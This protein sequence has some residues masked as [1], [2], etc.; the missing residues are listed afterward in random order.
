M[1]D[2]E[3]G[4]EERGL[5]RVHVVENAQEGNDPRTN[6][7]KVLGVVSLRRGSI[8]LQ[9]EV[10]HATLLQVFHNRDQK[11]VLAVNPVGLQQDKELRNVAG[12]LHAVVHALRHILVS[13]V[14]K[15]ELRP[16][17]ALSRF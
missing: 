5:E 13:K 3:R 7:Q 2:R 1:T 10:L 14:R 6:E 9:Q 4:E 12:T 11:G 16:D 8:A 15:L 17:H